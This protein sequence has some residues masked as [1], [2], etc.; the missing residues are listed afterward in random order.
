MEDNTQPNNQ[1]VPETD[2][3]NNNPETTQGQ[4]PPPEP[5]QTA[6]NTAVAAPV[7]GQDFTAPEGILAQWPGAFKLYKP[8][9]AAVMLNL[10]SILG[11]YVITFALNI[12]Y[13]VATRSLKLTLPALALRIIYE[14][15]VMILSAGIIYATIAGIRGKK[16]TISDALNAVFK[17]ALNIVAVSILLGIILLV[18]FVLLIVPFFFVMP[19]LVLALYFVL[20]KDLDPVEAI[21]ASWEY[22]KA[23]EGKFYGIIG[24]YLLI[25][26]PIVTI[27]GILATIYFGLMYSAAF[28]LFYAYL[29]N[30]R[31]PAIDQTK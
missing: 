23:S 31:P 15:V 13:T 14:I 9:K 24:V 5:S 2:Q 30:H 4:T 18:S 22:T 29:L 19:R 20:D 1:N 26:L 11:I 10:G 7:A 3:T 17:K 25:C 8:S 12:V 6:Q 21:K 28:A 16:I 27:I